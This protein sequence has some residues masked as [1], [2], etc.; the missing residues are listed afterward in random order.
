MSNGAAMDGALPDARHAS[1]SRTHVHTCICISPPART[2]ARRMHAWTH[3][4]TYTI[5]KGIY[6]ISNDQREQKQ[7][8]E[9]TKATIRE[10]KSNDQREQKQR[11]ERTKATI[12]ENKSNDQRKQKQR[13]ERTKVTIRENK[14]NDQR[15]QKQRSERTKATIRENKSNDQR[16]QK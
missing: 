3:A 1:V 10:N 16:E 4:H 15:E 11:S 6:T 14:S 12:R 5:R 9:R 7:R 8:S 2:D 13:S